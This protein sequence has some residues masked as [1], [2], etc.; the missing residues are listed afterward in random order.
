MVFSSLYFIFIFL[1]VVCI[2]YY[3]LKVM[4][5]NH[6]GVR[7][8]FL[9]IASLF[10]YAWGEPIYVLLMLTS[11]LLNYLFGLR[12]SKILLVF[13][14]IFNLGFLVFFKY[15]AFFVQNLNMIMKS[16]FSVPNLELPIGISFYTF[17][18]LS[19]VID[20]YRGKV[21]KQKNILN[22]AL[23][24]CLFPQ[25]IAGPIVR[26]IDIE[27]EITNRNENFTLFMDG[28][29]EFC[30]GLGA[31]V[32]IANNMAFFVDGVYGKLD[33][34]ISPIAW[35]AGLC[36]CFQIYFDFSGYSRMAIGL[37]KMFGFHFCENFN[38]PYCASSITDFWRRWHISLSTWFRDYVYIPLGGNRVRAGHHIFNILATW[39]LTGFWHGASWNFVF[40]GLFYGILLC[41]EKYVSLRFINSLKDK[42]LRFSAWFF[43]FLLRICTL[44]LVYFGWVLFRADDMITLELVL[45]KMFSSS[46]ALNFQTFIS[47][48]IENAD[49]CSKLVFLIP[50]IIFSFPI[51]PVIFK[52]AQKYQ[53]V[54]ILELIVDFAILVC[55]L[56]LL[57]GST[58]NPF[59][60]FRF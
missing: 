51:Y 50:A 19:Y 37:G 9:C 8:G 48:L 34:T 14:V 43:N 24:I 27:K 4:F 23:Y 25:L 2:V 36:Y 17:Q 10:F 31:K 44:I 5:P 29:K 49:L 38:Y 15:S 57:V 35:L 39:L 40:W 22:L 47:Y 28:L 59:I 52:T 26:Y 12:K 1:P 7:N 3:L 55:S 11:I 45:K 20:V 53:A 46:E 58:Y 30:R 33:G 56:A 18:A 41:F 21:E 32:I 13:A 54:Y 60:Y 16:N 42:N 6:I